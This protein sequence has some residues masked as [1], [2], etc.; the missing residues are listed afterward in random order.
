[1][2]INDDVF[3]ALL[4]M[5]SY[6]RGYNPG[7]ALA[8]TQLGAATLRTDVG[9]PTGGQAASFFAQA[10]TWNNH[11]V[12]SYRGTDQA[13]PSWENWTLGDVF[14]GW[15]TGAGNPGTT[16][17]RMAIEFYRSLVGQNV[18]PRS[19]NIEL[20]GHS[21]GGGLAGF[22]AGLYG[23]NA[24]MFDNMPFEKLT[25]DTHDLPPLPSDPTYQS[26]YFN[27]SAL[28][29]LAVTVFKDVPTRIVV[30]DTQGQ[31]SVAFLQD[32]IRPTPHDNTVARAG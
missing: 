14:N 21:L 28:R 7:I 31:P 2:A 25:N 1:M 29:Q 3:R 17:A 23:K 22:V 11:T 27:G 10:Y 20:T 18:D 13:T 6:N 19:A 16:Q 30:A 15:F 12:I 32:V 4:A 26:Y 24:V 8:G 5:D 9:Q